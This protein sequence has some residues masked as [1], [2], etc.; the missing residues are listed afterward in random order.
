MT[1]TELIALIQQRGAIAVAK[2][3]R[4]D[5]FVAGIRDGLDLT[6][7]HVDGN[8]SASFFV[9]VEETDEPAV[10]QRVPTGRT[11]GFTAPKQ[12]RI[13][14]APRVLVVNQGPYDVAYWQSELRETIGD[15]ARTTVLNQ[16]G[17]VLWI[18]N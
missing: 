12:R 1:D 11:W 5:F 10:A 16:H 6:N 9:Q 3:V 13:S 2:L 17:Q 4:E 15:E 14:T 8:A 18:Q 7:W